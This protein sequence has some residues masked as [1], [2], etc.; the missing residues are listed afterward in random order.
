[1]ICL[2]HLSLENFRCFVECQIEFHPK[3]TV[4]VARNGRGKTTILDGIA[5]AFA[6]FIDALV[7]RKQW[8]GFSQSDLRMSFREVLSPST[9]SEFGPI[10]L[11]EMISSEWH[12]V[13]ALAN[14]QGENV[15]WEF[16]AQLSD[17]RYSSS[18]AWSRPL[19]QIAKELEQQLTA[20]T[21]AH[22]APTRLPLLTYF[23]ASR[24]LTPAT[25]IKA[26]A[27]RTTNDRFRGYING[28]DAG[29]NYGAF[30]DWY[31]TM[32]RT[33][34]SLGTGAKIAFDVS[35]RHQPAA[36]LAAVNKAVDK[37]LQPA[38]G[39]HG[40]HW[41]KGA[42]QLMLRHPK[43]GRLPLSFLSDGI[44][45]A[46]ALVADVAHR[47][48]RLNPEFGEDAPL[49]TPGILLV[50]EIDLHLHPE[51]QQSVISSLREAFPMLQLILSTHSP[52]VIST[53][54]SQSIRVLN[55]VEDISIASTP[56]FQTR[57]VRSADV[58]SAVMDVDP[59][60]NVPESELL[61]HYRAM[62]ENGQSGTGAATEM[63]SRLIE[64]FGELHPLILDCDRLIRFTE[65]KR[66]RITP[67]GGNAET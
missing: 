44:R 18:R 12:R 17:T 30:I 15:S 42:S 66:R 10:E 38:T 54:N 62:I 49:E 59:V 31:M 23:H 39:W 27:G 55:S 41:E 21:D 16:Q 7:H 63:R 1:M 65:F 29:S 8:K 57:G 40:L 43:H 28:L 13:G 11:G 5:G 19:V 56:H 47:C 24:Q 53:V 9:E 4:L 25:K 35:S 33:L 22:V 50:D 64:H 45:N 48:A 36:L 34:G 51:W 67:G 20:D 52:Q 14:I 61:S 26:A 32:F 37:V 3:L 2:Q 58:L 6:P 46:V 60:P